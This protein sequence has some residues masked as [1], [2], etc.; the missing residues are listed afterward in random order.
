MTDTPMTPAREQEIRSMER[1]AT[2][3]PWTSVEATDADV[4]RLLAGGDGTPFKL[5]GRI[6][7]GGDAEF[8]AGSRQAVPE[9]LAEVDRLRA[10]LA[11]VEALK[12]ARFQ[13]CQVCGTGHEYGQP[14]STCEF[15]KQMDAAR[16][17]GHNQCFLAADKSEEKCP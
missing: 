3:G 8:I 15:N 12:P 1:A 7:P 11:E 5:L 4:H 2:R 10:R 17:A 13:D 9:L 14:C 16:S 6:T